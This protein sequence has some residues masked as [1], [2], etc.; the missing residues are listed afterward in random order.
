MGIHF[1]RLMVNTLRKYHKAFY[2]MQ[3]GWLLYIVMKRN[4]VI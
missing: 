4:A 2:L 3:N 1:L